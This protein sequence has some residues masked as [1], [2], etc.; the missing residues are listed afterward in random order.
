[1]QGVQDINEVDKTFETPFILFLTWKESRLKYKHL[2]PNMGRNLLSK[3]EKEGENRVW[4]PTVVFK[5]TND[6]TKTVVDDYTYITING[7]RSFIISNDKK[8]YR[9]SSSVKKS[10]FSVHENVYYF[11]GAENPL[12]MRRYYIQVFNCE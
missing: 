11:K 7:S 6:K 4:S 2:K 8:S 9:L 3:K 10:P 5:N 1:M 12:I